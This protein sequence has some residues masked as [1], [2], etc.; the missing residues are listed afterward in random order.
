MILE[1]GGYH[2]V[3]KMK[4]YFYINVLFNEPIQS[5]GSASINFSKSQMPEV[6]PSHE[7]M[8]SD[9]K[10]CKR[11]SCLSNNLK[12]IINNLS[13]SNP[14]IYIYLFISIRRHSPIIYVLRVQ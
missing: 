7:L 6:F 11:K 13:N 8:P 3:H 1:T 4:Y 10:I 9:I 12:L 5:G 14:E 2:N